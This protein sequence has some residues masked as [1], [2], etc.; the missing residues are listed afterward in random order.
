V[1]RS[2][3]GDSVSP[4][5][6]L[7]LIVKD[8]AANLPT[9]LDSVVG[10][11]D[12]IIVVDTGSTDGTQA[13]ATARG[14]TLIQTD[15][16]NDFSRAR[17]LGLAAARGAWILVLDADES[18]PEE[19]RAAIRALIAQPAT[20]AF[21]LITRSTDVHGQILRG[22]ILRLF[23]NRPDV[24]F[25]F[26]IHEAVNPDLIR[27]GVPIRDTKI[28]I[29]HSGYA[30]AATMARKAQRNRTIIEAALAN[31][32]RNGE[33]EAESHL[34]YYYA[35]TFYDAQ[36]RAAAAREYDACVANASAPDGKLARMARLRAAEC[37][38]LLGDFA[39]AQARL[40]AEPDP[41]QHPAA[42][43]LGGQLAVKRGESRRAS[44]WCE[45]VLAV[46]DA[47]FLPPVSLAAVKFK[48]LNFLGGFWADHGRTDI[49]V[50][51]LRLALDIKKGTRDGTSVELASLYREIV[52]PPEKPGTGSI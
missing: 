18:L 42:L 3:T 52:T 34:R 33:R 28:E 41:T 7:C 27:A 23:P 35:G 24:R 17:N 19:S 31:A 37:Y 12:E 36:D 16:D 4:R 2:T 22:S 21:N 14:A 38:F 51:I 40:P 10:V 32:V 26:P 9:C 46:E 50:R 8:E 25:Q 43:Y 44:R 39:A 29:A 45:A 11:A 48:A 49:G 20:E 5:L 6:S 13:L 1:L 15:W 30:D 47:A